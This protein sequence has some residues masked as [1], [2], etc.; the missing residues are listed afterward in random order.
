MK[1]ATI[2]QIKNELKGRSKEDL[3]ELSLKLAKFKKESKEFLTYLLFEA[4]NEADYVHEV[5]LEMS[6][7]FKTVNTSSAYLAKKTIRKILRLTKKYIRFSKNKASEAD[8]LIHFCTELIK[9][10]PIVSKSV[11]LQNIYLKQMEL[12]KKAIDQ[13]HPDLQFDY[14]SLIE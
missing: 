9:L 6:D 4:D 12:A 13:L 2:T 10:K 5:K 11:Q 14:L 8:L 1:A 3:V 7:L